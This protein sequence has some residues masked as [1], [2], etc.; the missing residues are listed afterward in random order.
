MKNYLTEA[1]GT[2]FLVLV[3][4]LTVSTGSE[5]APL[6]IGSILMV[7]VYAGGYISGWHYNPAVTLWA[8]IAGKLPSK[9]A[10][11]YM[12]SQII[13][14]FLAAIVNYVLV[15]EVLIVAPASW[16][17]QAIIAELI[18]TFALVY[19]VL[20]TAASEATEGNSNYGLAIWF[21]VMT[22]AYAVG[23]ISGWAFNPA[24]AVGPQLFDLIKWGMSI[25]T[26]WIYL[27]ACFWG[28][29]LAAL[30]YNF[31]NNNK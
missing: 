6:A 11:P 26:V 19:V 12:I 2:F 28:A 5:F 15:G 17:L 3:I 25:W 9:E 30:R 1:L 29:I 27:V 31:I 8:T 18:F 23:G 10:I 4:W 20:N 16:S 7:M 21:T 14:A 22:A 24:V 13:W